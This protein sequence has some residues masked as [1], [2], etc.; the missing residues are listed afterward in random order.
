[1]GSATILSSEGHS[2]KNQSNP[3]SSST[4]GTSTLSM[5][6]G[7]PPTVAGNPLPEIPDLSPHKP[8]AAKGEN[9][10]HSLAHSPPS[11]PKSQQI[12][13]ESDPPVIDKEGE[14]EEERS[15]KRD[16]SMNE[17]E[18]LEVKPEVDKTPKENDLL[19]EQPEKSN[20]STIAEDKEKTVEIKEEPISPAEDLEDQSD[21]TTPNIP[22]ERKDLD[23][24]EIKS[25]TV[26]N[27]IN[28]ENIGK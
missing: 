14:L 12:K 24:S 13:I 23:I 9:V 3:P 4:S 19:M 20:V 7:L 1:M 22:K 25:G 8:T 16:D 10:S 26:E 21:I 2:E 28:T 27:A 18:K 15:T 6:L 5:L 11:S 17:V